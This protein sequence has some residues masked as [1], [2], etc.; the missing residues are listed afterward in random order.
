MLNKLE[1]H[2]RKIT[3]LG[4][5]FLIW[6]ILL[7]PL[8]GTI[9]SFF[10]IKWGFLTAALILI[11]TIII[12]YQFRDIDIFTIDRLSE[13]G[14]LCI[15]TLISVLIYKEY[16]PSISIQQDQSIYI[17]KAL[18][19]LNHGYT[20]KPMNML[21]LL[22]ENGIV[23]IANNL[24]NYGI[25]ENGNTLVGNKLY[26]D[27]YAGGAYF[28]AL[29]GLIKRNYIFYGQ[30]LITIANTW[31]MYFTV[32][33][34]LSDKRGITSILYTL[35][36]F[37]SPICVWFGRSSSTE[38]MALF[39]FLLI[40]LL[41]LSENLTSNHWMII[42]FTVVL[43]GRIDYFLI[44]IIGIFILTYRNRLVGALTVVSASTFA[45][46]CSKVFWIYYDRIK[47]RDM[48]LVKY[49]IPLF[50]GV[51]FLTIIIRKLN[52][53]LIEKIYNSVFVKVGLLVWGILITLMMFRDSFTS[54][55]KWGRFTEFGLNIRS[56]EELIMDHLFLV[57]PGFVL[58][59][60]LVGAYKLIKSNMNFMAGIYLIGLVVIYSY[61]VYKSGNAPQMYFLL[62]R[63][64][65]VFIP[66][67]LILFAIVMN[68][69]SEKTKVLIAF[70]AFI[71]SAN[72]LG[73]SMQQVEYATLE[74]S[75]RHFV[76]T[77]DEDEISTIFYNHNDKYDI[78]PIVAYGNY[79][80]VPLQ[81]LA[82]L[83]SVINNNKYYDANSSLYISTE[84]LAGVNEY[85][86]IN[87]NYYRMGENYEELPKEYYYI[88]VNLYV[89]RM[90]DLF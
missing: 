18:N 36:F 30:T 10:N 64:Y 81:D 15:L 41:L 68:E 19:L 86:N 33:K 75:V 52:E 47:I 88:E 80:V 72:L 49:Q 5:Q 11:L 65:N 89:Y 48:K 61:F 77:Y 54:E 51:F 34:V 23:D 66:G 21:A 71:M 28:Y 12:A 35:T 7:S 59:I 4:I 8:I 56:Y 78:S 14:Y 45:I 53:N 9:G 84:P 73:N 70:C 60:G 85:Q 83:D 67:L 79:D 25:L 57:F 26:T 87:L 40:F 22:K 31:L 20:Y 46:I 17:M 74:Q 1:N 43:I 50:I 16:S 38:T 3:S 62:R 69:L 90:N 32:K 82:E 42:P 13:W 2:V 76:Y 55:E 39:L 44:T 6:A 24:N 27:F 37:V 29:C 63:Y 58:I